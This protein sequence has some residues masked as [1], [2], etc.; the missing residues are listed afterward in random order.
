MG[1]SPNKVHRG[2]LPRPIQL[3]SKRAVVAG[4]DCLGGCWY[5]GST[6]WAKWL[7]SCRTPCLTNNC[8]LTVKFVIFLMLWYMLLFIG[9]VIVCRVTLSLWSNQV[10]G[11]VYTL[12]NSN[13][14][15]KTTVSTIDFRNSQFVGMARQFQCSY[16]DNCVC[17]Q[18][19]LETTN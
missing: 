8:L 16:E 15:T 1:L 13:A 14:H 7:W 2:R 6:F 10:L 3:I 18:L 9:N 17:L 5:A 11:K 19:I 12:D 4:Y